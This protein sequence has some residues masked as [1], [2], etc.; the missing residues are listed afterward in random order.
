MFSTPENSVMHELLEG[1]GC[2][3]NFHRLQFLFLLFFVLICQGCGSNIIRNTVP[4]NLQNQVNVL[5]SA[6]LRFIPY[7]VSEEFI[8][9][10]TMKMMQQQTESKL[11]YEDNGNTKP[12]YILALSGGGEG[13]AFGAGILSGWTATGTRPEF[14]VVTGI[15]TGALIAPFAFLGSD[16]DWVLDDLY[17]ETTAKQL[18]RRNGIFSIFRLDALYDTAPLRKLIAEYV[19]TETLQKIS[20]EHLKGRRL[21]IGTTNLDS[22]RTTIWDMGAIASSKH[23]DSQELFR[24]IML[25]SASIPGVYPAVYI[26]VHAEGK[27]F[28]EMHVDGGTSS[29]VFVYPPEFKLK[30]LSKQYNYNR[31][32]NLYVI[33]NSKLKPKGQVFKPGIRTIARRSIKKLINTQGIGDIYR[34]YLTSQRDKVNFN[35]TFIPTEIEKKSKEEF[36]TDYMQEL[37]DYG[38]KHMINGYPWRQTLPGFE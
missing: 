7:E 17:T 33:F 27:Q 14:T 10:Y 22:L 25:A 28:D 29:Q 30:E 6:D 38:Y 9:S 4:E 26:N 36:D 3:N 20:L 37:F 11:L 16:Y 2:N 1:N 35:M 15:S 12:S 18:V 31:E 34:I 5:D 23:A 13:G 21:F 24:N 8:L 19:T 32:R